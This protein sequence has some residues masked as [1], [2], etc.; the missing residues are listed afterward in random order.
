M[1]NNKMAYSIALALLGYAA[2]TLAQSGVELQGTKPPQPLPSD[3]A[4]LP[5]VQAAPVPQSMTAG[6][7]AVTLQ[8]VEI[9]GNKA[10]DTATLL[11]QLGEVKGKRLDMAGLNALANTLS[12]YYRAMGYPFAQAYL[13]PQNLKDGVLRINVIE[14]RYGVVTAV[15]KDNLPAGAQPF[16]DYSLKHGDPIQNQQLERTMLI[17]DDQPGM[18]IRPVLKPGASQGEADLIVGVERSSNVSGE[19]GLDNTGARS[20]GEYRARGALFLN[21]PFQYGDKVSLNGMYTNEHMWLGSADYEAP[22]GASGL[23]GQIGYAHTSYQ[24]GGQFT[25]LDA[26][27]FAKVTSAKLS[28]PLIR[29]QATNVLLTLGV[30]HK[31]LEDDYRAIN[32]S[33]TKSSDNVPV[34]LQFDKR[35][36][37]LGGGVTYGSLSWVTGKL[38]LDAGTATTDA[39]TARTQGHFSKINL[40]VARIQKVA[41]NLSFYGRYSG[42]WADKNLDSSEKINLGGYYGV[43]AYPLGE[44]VGDRGWFTQLELRYAINTVIPF[45]FYDFGK[46]YVNAHPWDA[47]SNAN[48][49]LAGSGVGVRS[50]FG[51]W[52]LDATLAWRTEGGAATSDNR[53]RNPRAFFMLGYR[54]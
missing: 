26:Q 23:R 11:R 20:T 33:R 36:A 4:V 21:S 32:M 17:L 30:Q 52:S 49:T 9:T 46:S 27:G 14:G 10:I 50:L 44:G 2:Q 53:D 35:D 42:Q 7:P 45:I 25:N 3:A 29:S 41:G 19:L 8:L 39:T 43:R 22:L 5:N 15:G 37:L 48:R 54:I 51:K 13:P 28:Y 47:N 31:N 40:D 6:G 38:D 1:K 16:L 34:G 24:L 12:S 18:K